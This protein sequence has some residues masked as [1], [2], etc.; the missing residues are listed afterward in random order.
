MNFV[1]II[2]NLFQFNRTNWQAIVLCFLAAT[3][4]WFFTAFNKVHTA[5]LRFPLRFEF[6]NQRFVAINP[7]PHQI[8]INVSGSGWELFRKSV[9][10][11]LPEL[12][13]P[14][15][16]PQDLKKLPTV[17]LTPVLASQLG[18]LQINY[19]VTDTLHL[20]VEERKSKTFRVAVD[21]SDV[22]FREGFG[23]TGETKA[24]PDTVVIEGPKSIVS[25]IPDTIVLRVQGKQISKSFHDEV[26]VP[27]FS[28]E[29]INRNPPVVS[30]SIEVSEMV[31]IEA[32]IKI[33]TVNQ[34]RKGKSS[35]TDSVK[36]FIRLP[37][38]QFNDLRA[39]GSQIK[40][41]LDLKDAI[42]GSDPRYPKIIGLPVYAQVVSIDSMSFKID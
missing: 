13:I 1:R 36:V 38:N 10:I 2:L 19:M 20:Q 34:P 3:V 30:V 35:F 37:V 7:L 41:I 26:E 21:L 32:I 8:S 42:K 24:V 17:V 22:K 40:A 29:S 11:K 39:K 9:G 14:L 27:L 16:Q 18:G 6:D 5:T 12:L 31:T 25:A 15:E 28:S 33:Q 4:F 23:S